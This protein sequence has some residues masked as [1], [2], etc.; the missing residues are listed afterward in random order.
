MTATGSVSP[1]SLNQLPKPYDISVA[2]QQA[3]K[4]NSPSDV[5]TCR[6]AMEIS[7]IEDNDIYRGILTY[8]S[9]CDS[10]EK[11]I[12]GLLPDI[13]SEDLLDDMWNNVTLPDLDVEGENAANMEEL[14]Q[15][16]KYIDGEDESNEKNKTQQSQKPQYARRLLTP[17]PSSLTYK[18]ELVN[19]EIWQRFSS[20][21]TEMVITK[22]GR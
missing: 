8:R 3:F 14:E 20:V 7:L 6:P 22:N 10:L 16:V 11:E 2:V 18:V 12:E 13:I 15:F 5:E 21:G 1:I 4:L 17:T 9:S 19:S